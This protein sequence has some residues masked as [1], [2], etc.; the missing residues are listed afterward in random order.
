MKTDNQSNNG[1]LNLDSMLRNYAL[2]I[3]VMLKE[4]KLIYFLKLISY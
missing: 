1:I 2:F 3:K 4:I